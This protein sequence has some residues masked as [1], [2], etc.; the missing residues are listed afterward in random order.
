MIGYEINSSV[1]LQLSHF[2][3]FYMHSFYIL[4]R[5]RTKRERDRKRKKDRKADRYGQIGRSVVR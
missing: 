4:E 2:A 5:Q 3:A 1:K